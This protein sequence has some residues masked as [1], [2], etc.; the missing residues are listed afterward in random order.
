MT[1]PVLRRLPVTK[2]FLLIRLFPAM[3]WQNILVV[4]RNRWNG[5]VMRR[6]FINLTMA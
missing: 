2:Q 1:V 4:A 6:F 3:S 5:K